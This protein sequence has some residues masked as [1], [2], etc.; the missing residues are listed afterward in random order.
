MRNEL[1]RADIRVY[2]PKMN[3]EKFIQHVVNKITNKL[4]EVFPEA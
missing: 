4:H 2:Y 3:K 1:E